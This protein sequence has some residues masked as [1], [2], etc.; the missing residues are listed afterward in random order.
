MTGG[1]PEATTGSSTGG[2]AI[3]DVNANP[4][5]SQGGSA[6]A[7]SARFGT[8]M[9]TALFVILG[10]VLAYL[11]GMLLGDGGTLPSAP[12]N[13]FYL[14][15]VGMLVSYLVTRAPARRLGRLWA[16]AV[17]RVTG[18]G[19]DV[20]VAA[21]AGATVGL[22][23]TILLNT[24]LAEVP[25]FN[26]YW[27]I[28]IAVV[29]VVGWSGFLVMNRRLVPFLRTTPANEPSQVLE[30]AVR[31]KVVDTSAIIDGRIV[32][33]AQANFLDGKLILPKVVLAELQRLADSEDTLRRQRGRRG[34]EVLDNLAANPQVRTEVVDFGETLKLPVDD[35]LVKLCIER[36][37]DLITTDYN[38]SRVAGLQGV[39]VLNVNQ[40]ANSVKATYMPGERLSLNIVK[41]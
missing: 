34:L 12:N 8:N 4:A 30:H 6:I 32:E 36:G 40:L 7:Q 15:V 25:G 39:R 11:G 17:Q 28:L 38:L 24:V 22:L 37:F 10:G 14:T 41:P 20:V 1:R 3:T 29:M 27:S 16:R 23:L 13:L 21:G 18:V 19:P 9:A 33:V 35:K 31:D 26:W 2:R 5:A